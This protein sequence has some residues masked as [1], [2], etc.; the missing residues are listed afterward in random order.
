LHKCIARMVRKQPSK[1]TGNDMEE[2][3]KPVHTCIDQ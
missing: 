1:Q 2:V 3:Q